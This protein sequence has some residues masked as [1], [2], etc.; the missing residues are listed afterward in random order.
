MY[1]LRTRPMVVR[2]PNP[3][4][5]IQLVPGVLRVEVQVCSAG[6]GSRV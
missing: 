6:A 1:G 3:E 2:G 4:Q 5:R